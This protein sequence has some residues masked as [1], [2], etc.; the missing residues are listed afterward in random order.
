MPSK[1]WS[2]TY[3]GFP[4]AVVRR[5]R[6]EEPTCRRCGAP[7]TEVDHVV[8]RAD[9]LQLGWTMAAIQ[10][11]RNAQGLCHECHE[12]KTELERR[13]GIERVSKRRPVEPHP[14]LRRDI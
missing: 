4:P 2:G 6:L 10:D 8:G 9:A 12:A 11:R 1:P 14:G 5:V 13:R 7:A 3:R